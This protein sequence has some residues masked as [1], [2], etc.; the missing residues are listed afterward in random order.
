MGGSKCLAS[1]SRQCIGKSLAYVSGSALVLSSV[2]TREVSSDLLLKLKTRSGSLWTGCR[3]LPKKTRISQNSK[4]ETRFVFFCFGRRLRPDE[5]QVWSL[6]G[7]AV[8]A[9]GAVKTKHDSHDSVICAHA[10]WT[11]P[12]SQ[13]WVASKANL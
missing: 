10:I 2:G 3:V 9:R 6:Y 12:F 13:R 8:S 5:F 7:T 1:R 11:H 4:L